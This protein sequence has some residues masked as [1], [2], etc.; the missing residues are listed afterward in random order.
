[1]E[2]IFFT[3]WIAGDFLGLEPME[4]WSTL[5]AYKIWNGLQFGVESDLH[6]T[7]PPTKH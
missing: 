1:M 2:K 5:N 6:L 7:V 3:I 4:D